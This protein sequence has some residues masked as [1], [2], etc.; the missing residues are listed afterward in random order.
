[1]TSEQLIFT[2]SLSVIEEQRRIPAFLNQTAF[3][4]F[5][6]ARLFFGGA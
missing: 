1:M 3:G 2:E 4:L 6:L 5:L